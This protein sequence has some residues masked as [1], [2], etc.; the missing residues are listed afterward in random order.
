M[1]RTPEFEELVRC[2][3]S[4]HDPIVDRIINNIKPKKSKRVNRK[5][6]GN[7]SGNNPRYNKRSHRFKDQEMDRGSLVIPIF[8]R[9]DGYAEIRIQRDIDDHGA[10]KGKMGFVIGK[11]DTKIETE[12]EAALREVEEEALIPK[13]VGELIRIDVMKTTRSYILT[14]F[15]DIL[16]FDT[17]DGKGADVYSHSRYSVEDVILMVKNGEL[18]FD[19]GASFTTASIMGLI[20][21]LDYPSSSI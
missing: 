21:G 1:I 8:L 18:L 16:P 11:A 7:N 14:A 2:L 4:G 17:I 20:P 3:R 15:V 5:I 13:S 19:H 12:E 9:S 10:L 6:D